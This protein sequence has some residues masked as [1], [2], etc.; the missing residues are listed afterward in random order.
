MDALEGPSLANAAELTTFAND[1][2]AY[3]RQNITWA[4]Q[5]AAFTFAGVS[6]FLAYLNSHQAFGFLRGDA[7]F[8]SAHVLLVAAAICLVIAAA[9]SFV[10]YWPRTK[11]LRA[12]VVFWGAIA[13]NDSAGAY[14]ER[15]KAKTADELAVAKL[16][17]TYELAKIC[18]RKFRWADIAIRFAV[19]GFG[20]AIIYSLGWL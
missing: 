15:A 14:V 10:T 17:H 2:H 6:G 7:A 9:A 5:K 18:E 16:E 1:V 12:G 13:K 20:L 3:L 11:G 19:I 8:R 4:D